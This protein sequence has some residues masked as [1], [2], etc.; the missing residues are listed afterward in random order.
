MD[1]TSD[2]RITQRAEK[3]P[4]VISLI[5]LNQELIYFNAPNAL[6]AA[7]TLAAVKNFV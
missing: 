7:A 2:I 5:T 1:E 4:A 3:P 6:C